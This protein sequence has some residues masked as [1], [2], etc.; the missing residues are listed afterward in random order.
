MLLFIR[1]QFTDYDV[2][3]LPLQ[4]QVSCLLELFPSIM[5]V[6]LTCGLARLPLYMVMIPGG[7]PGSHKLP[8]PCPVF[9]SVMT[10]VR[11][12]SLRGQDT[13]FLG[14]KA[15]G[16]RSVVLKLEHASELPRRLVQTHITGPPPRVSDSVCLG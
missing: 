8:A 5:S 13:L 9:T 6:E 15:S 3:S 7:I 14:S 16:T 10:K 11:P 12:I 2:Q 1:V 4:F